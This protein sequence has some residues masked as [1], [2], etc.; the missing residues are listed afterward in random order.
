M[1][2]RTTTSTHDYSTY[3]GFYDLCHGERSEE[4]ETIHY[5][6]RT[7]GK[8]H[9]S[10]LDLACGT[11]SILHGLARKGIVDCTGVDASGAMLS[12]AKSK[13]PHAKVFQQDM[14]ALNT[15]RAYDAIYCVCN[16]INHLL[17]FSDWKKTIRAIWCHL[18][19]NGVFILEL[20]T[21]EYLKGMKNKVGDT[22]DPNY[23]ARLTKHHLRN[24]Y[25]WKVYDKASQDAIYIVVHAYP[26][27][28]VGKLLSRHFTLEHIQP[29]SRGANANVKGRFYLVLRKRQRRYHGIQGWQINDV[30]AF[31]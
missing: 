24:R 5:L 23:A 21:P 29:Y 30:L 8:D 6:M 9:P 27:K 18:N 1:F 2:T 28:K 16:S 12:I 13:L 3:A 22:E 14:Q 25:S 26:L 31:Y 19:D 7:F 4:I 10:V 17:R 11:G 15:G 20:D